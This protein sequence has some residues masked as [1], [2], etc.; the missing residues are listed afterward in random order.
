M[1][2]DMHACDSSSSTKPGA[3]RWTALRRAGLTS[4]VKR[5]PRA[6]GC[7]RIGPLETGILDVSAAPSLGNIS[8]TTKR[9]RPTAT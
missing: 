3:L 1:A 6:R 8:S 4:G 9:T 2:L 7:P 5:A